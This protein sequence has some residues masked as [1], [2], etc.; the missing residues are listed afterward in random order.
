MRRVSVKE[1]Q[2]SLRILLD[3]VKA[4]EEVVI[5]RRGKD[6]ARIVP[7][8]Q[9]SL[10]LPDLSALR[11]SIIRAHGE[12]ISSLVSRMRKEERY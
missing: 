4:G 5:S 1:T 12:P 9:K 3:R 6:V 8:L 10:R 11:A 7:P 2:S